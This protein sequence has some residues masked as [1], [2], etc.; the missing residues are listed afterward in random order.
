MRK[1]YKYNIF[2]IYFFESNNSCSINISEIFWQKIKMLNSKDFQLKLFYG[3]NKIDL[4]Y[5][6]REIAGGKQ[7][8]RV[9]LKGELSKFEKKFIEENLEKIYLEVEIVVEN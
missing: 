5:Y 2:F 8:L 3:E 7:Y 1:Y 4:E 9:I 6:A